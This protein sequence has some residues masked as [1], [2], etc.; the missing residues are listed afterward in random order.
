MVLLA[1]LAVVPLS[2]AGFGMYLYPFQTVGI[3]SLQDFIQEWQSPNFH[4]RQVWPFAAMIFLLLGAAGASGKRLR[5]EEFLLV[6]GWGVLS[7]YAGRNIAIFALAGTLVLCRHGSD[8]LEEWGAALGVRWSPR[9]RVPRGQLLL[10]WVLLVLLVLAVAVKTALVLPE[11]ANR[12]ELEAFLPMDAVDFLAEHPPEGQLFNSYNWGAYL[13]WALP[14]V[15]V[16]VDGRTDLYS[17]EV[18]G[19][20]FQ[21]ARAEPGWEEALAKW[22]V[23]TVLL[24]PHLP[25]VNALLAAGWEEAYADDIAVILRR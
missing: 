23:D 21:V 10:N 24:E 4:E 3:E 22:Q 14:E 8:V 13:L 7:L 5:S 19:E 6:A 12:K 25:V 16:F 9:R 11:T 2:T 15:P 20:W 18:I 1:M 17:D